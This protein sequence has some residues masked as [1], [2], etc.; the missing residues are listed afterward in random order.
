[1]NWKQKGRFTLS[2]ILVRENPQQVAEIFRLID[3]VP[4]RVTPLI[5]PEEIR[6]YA[7][8]P[9]FREIEKG[10]VVPE[11]ILNVKT[12]STGHVESVGVVEQ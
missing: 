1:M 9:R 2:E 3:C 4:V 12:D 11:Y 8:S 5:I 10:R 7:L 6:Y